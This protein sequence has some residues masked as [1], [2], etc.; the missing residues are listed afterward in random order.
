MSLIKLTDVKKNYG[1]QW[2][3]NGVSLSLELGEQVA[4]KGASGSGK[5]TLLYLLGGL[6]KAS[7]G[8]IEVD[9]MY[10]SKTTDQDLAIYRNQ[11]IGFVFQFHFLLS[12]LTALDNVKMPIRI[13]GKKEKEFNSKIEMLAQRLGVEHCLKK[14][15]FQLS[16]GEQQ[17]ISIMRSLI[18]SPPILLCDE[19]TGNLDSQNSANVIDLLQELARPSKTTLIVVTH[20]DAVA[21]KFS[22]QLMMKDGQLI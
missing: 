8:S 11:K 19:P 6:E 12:T 10:L 13:A 14:F 7:S 22:K 21:R 2:A 9:G 5:S 15:P 18:L 4:I 16:G 3:V 20:D 17:R 1:N